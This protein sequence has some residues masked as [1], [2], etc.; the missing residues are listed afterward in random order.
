MMMTQT[1]PDTRSGI[2]TLQIGINARCIPTRRHSQTDDP[3]AVQYLT[4][5]R[6][7]GEGAPAPESGR[8]LAR[9]GYVSDRKESRRQGKPA[10]D[11]RGCPP[12][13][14]AKRETYN[15]IRYSANVRLSD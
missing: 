14:S 12:G 9:G 6:A 15:L 11:L 13:C 4:R 7:R 5:E 3:S 1:S 8:S 2:P 10:V